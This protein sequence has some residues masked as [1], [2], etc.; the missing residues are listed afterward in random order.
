M[1]YPILIGS[2]AIIVLIGMV[3]FLIPIFAEHVRRDLGNAKLPLLTRIMM[4]ISD[5]MLSFP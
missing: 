3:L 4:G 1:V 5:A 2:F